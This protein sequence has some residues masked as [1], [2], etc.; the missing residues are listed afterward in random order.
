MH[1]TGDVSF[2]EYA[3]IVVIEVV[4]ARQPAVR[5]EMEAKRVVALDVAERRDVKDLAR[6]QR[7]AGDERRAMRVRG[8]S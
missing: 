4:D 3:R 6:C 5:S 2:K 7:F 1:T 8:I